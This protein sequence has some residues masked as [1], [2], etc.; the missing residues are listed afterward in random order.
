MVKHSFLLPIYAI[1]TGICGQSCFFSQFQPICFLISLLYI[2]VCVHLSNNLVKVLRPFLLVLGGDSVKSEGDSRAGK[3]ARLLVNES[4]DDDETE[5][6]L[7]RIQDESTFEDLCGD[8]SFPGEESAGSAIESG[9]W[10]LLDGHTLAHVF[11]FLRSDMKS[12]TIASLTCR[13]WRA[14]VRFYKGIS[15][16]VDL[17]SVGPNCTD[18]LIRKIL[19]S[20]VHV[21]C[22][23]HHKYFTLCKFLLDLLLAECL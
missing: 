10:G 2:Y 7:Q 21:C 19:V 15:R 22:E 12:L 6:D 18:S 17:S 9:G 23:Q 14:A 11:H 5:E 8:V 1:N 3:R 20:L 16:Q 13:H 4:D